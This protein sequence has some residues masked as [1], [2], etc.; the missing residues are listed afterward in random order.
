[1]STLTDLQLRSPQPAG[2][3][4]PCVVHHFVLKTKMFHQLCDSRPAVTS[5]HT[6]QTLSPPLFIIIHHYSHYPWVVSLF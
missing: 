6:G 3:I 4:A 2:G 1:M 5:Y